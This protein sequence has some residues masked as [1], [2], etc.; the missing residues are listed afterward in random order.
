MASDTSIGFN[1][2][3]VN[4]DGAASKDVQVDGAAD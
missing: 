1:W 2:L 3:L 4:V